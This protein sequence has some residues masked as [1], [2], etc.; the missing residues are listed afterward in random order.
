[1]SEPSLAQLADLPPA[2]TLPST[3]RP[4]A[5]GPHILFP[6]TQYKACG[7]HSCRA[8][9]SSV[10]DRCLSTL[11]GTGSGGSAQRN[12]PPGDRFTPA[13]G[14]EYDP[15]KI[16]EMGS[17]MP[18]PNSVGPALC[19]HASKPSAPEHRPL[20]GPRRPSLPPQSPN[21]SSQ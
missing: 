5:W 8:L 15:D 10:G 3:N 9:Q 13:E 6:T 14:S 1:M 16:R 19:P 7:P 12:L 11:M 21:Q 18:S 20:L 2:L 4:H 17:L